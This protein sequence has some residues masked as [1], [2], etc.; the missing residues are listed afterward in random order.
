MLVNGLVTTEVAEHQ[1]SVQRPHAKGLTPDQNLE[2]AD[3]GLRQRDVS[4]VCF[5][6]DNSTYCCTTE[7]V[8]TCHLCFPTI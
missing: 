5:T 3:G 2:N 4:C 7:S 1:P 8:I 6:G